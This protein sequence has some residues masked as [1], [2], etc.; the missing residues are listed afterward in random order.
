IGIIILLVAAIIYNF[1]SVVY[2]QSNKYFSHNYWQRFPALKQT[3]FNSKYAKKNG[4]PVPPDET[5]YA[6]AGGY[7]I[8]GN[9]PLTVVPEVP[10]LGKYLI[11]TSAILF[12]NE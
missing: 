5:I 1:G 9:S 2:L 10:P 6:F 4:N 11:G 3:Y 8:T 12:D 7:L